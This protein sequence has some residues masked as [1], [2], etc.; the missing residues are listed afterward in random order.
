LQQEKT[1]K[2]HSRKIP[3]IIFSFVVKSDLFCTVLLLFSLAVPSHDE[4]NVSDEEKT[5][6]GRTKAQSE[7]KGGDPVVRALFFLQV[8]VFTFVF[9][10]LLSSF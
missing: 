4:Q 6:D 5:S 7:G 1:I 9:N 10:A 8:V 2:R 3:R